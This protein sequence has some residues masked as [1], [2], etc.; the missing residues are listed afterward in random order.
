MLRRQVSIAPW[1]APRLPGPMTSLRCSKKARN[2]KCFS[3]L[4]ST[5]CCLDDLLGRGSQ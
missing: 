2:R 4:V 3:A 1:L 5:E